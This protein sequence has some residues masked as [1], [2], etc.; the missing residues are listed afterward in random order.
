MKSKHLK[1]V[2]CFVLSLALAACG[3]S[4]QQATTISDSEETD[5]SQESQVANTAPLI[6]GLQIKRTKFGL[7]DRAG[8]SVVE[9]S[10]AVVDTEQNAAEIHFYNRRDQ[11]LE[12]FKLAGLAKDQTTQVIHFDYVIDSNKQGEILLDIW[13]RDSRGADSNI[14][15]AMLDVSVAYGS[16]PKLYLDIDDLKITLVNGI[17]QNVGCLDDNRNSVSCAS[18]KAKDVEVPCINGTLEDS[19]L[20]FSP[21]F[22]LYADKAFVGDY[23]VVSGIANNNGVYTN[24]LRR[25]SAC[26]L[27]YPLA[28]LRNVNSIRHGEMVYVDP[29]GNISNI[30]ELTSQIIHN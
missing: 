30:I 19:N 11:K 3:G 13:V 28:E 25:V 8:R 5:T 9:L 2:T 6:S 17:P 18:S 14:L 7:G 23:W 1:Y 29:T 10:M 21:F 12:Q 15:N 24:T 20:E 22:Y 27:T 16:A 4:E 26:V